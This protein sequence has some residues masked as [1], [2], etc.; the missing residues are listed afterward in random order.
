[1]IVNLL[2]R[3]PTRGSNQN[4][5]SSLSQSKTAYVF[6]PSALEQTNNDK[7]QRTR[8]SKARTI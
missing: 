2:V 3:R 8:I 6:I 4:D 5:R 1:L 7:R